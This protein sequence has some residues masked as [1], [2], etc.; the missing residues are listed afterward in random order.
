VLR[1]GLRIRTLRNAKL[2]IEVG[3]K[4]MASCDWALYAT[5]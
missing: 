5:W 4:D 3:S 2:R 1:R